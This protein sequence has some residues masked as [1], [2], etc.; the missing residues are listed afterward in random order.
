MNTPMELGD[1][2]L[3]LHCNRR[4]F[5]LGAVS[6]GFTPLMAGCSLGK[7]DT[8][9]PLY[10]LLYSA[11]C[12]VHAA[13]SLTT[14]SS[15]TKNIITVRKRHIEALQ[16]EIKRQEKLWKAPSEPPHISQK[17]PVSLKLLQQ[18]LL[19]ASQEALNIVA[20]NTGYRAGLAGSIAASCNALA[21][22]VL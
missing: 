10:Q 5:L 18:H 6:L 15:H 19:K 3:A 14:L 16:E 20:D 9:D 11:Q 2:S 17:S 12:D 7:H 22:V 4:K 13:L 21:K 1:S 8:A